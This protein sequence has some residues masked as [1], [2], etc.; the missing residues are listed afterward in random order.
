MKIHSYVI[1][2]NF[3]NFKT[4]FKAQLVRISEKMILYL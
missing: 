1:K 4:A 3:S 2:T